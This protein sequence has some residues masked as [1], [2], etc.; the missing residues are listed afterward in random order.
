VPADVDAAAAPA[1]VDAAASPDTD[2]S[3]AAPPDVDGAGSP[4]ADRSDA[5]P[6]EKPKPRRTRARKRPASD[7]AA[8][9]TEPSTPPAEE[10]A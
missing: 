10:A 5:A 7:E 6:A 4:D 9:P 8:G 3:E 1:D 2:G